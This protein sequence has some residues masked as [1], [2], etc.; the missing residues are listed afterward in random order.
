MNAKQ[1]LFVAMLALS[2]SAL[3]VPAVMTVTS[4]GVTLSSDTSAPVGSRYQLTTIVNYDTDSANLWG[5]YDIT[6][7][8]AKFIVAGQ[9]LSF[10]FFSPPAGPQSAAITRTGNTTSFAMSSFGVMDGERFRTE[11][12]VSW[13]TDQ[14]LPAND[15]SYAVT[16]TDPSYAYAL[17]SQSYYGDTAFFFHLQPETVQI[18]VSAVPEPQTWAM[19]LAGVGLAGFAARRRDRKVA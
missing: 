19:M 5:D 6:G 13:N 3:A 2:T 10:E 11:M 12:Y 17:A 14:P 16:V 1:L 18:N 7:F 15:Q 8:S 9:D 4:T